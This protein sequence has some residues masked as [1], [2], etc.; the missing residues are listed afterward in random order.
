MA[1]FLFLI[2]APLDDMNARHFSPT[3]KISEV[4]IKDLGSRFSISQQSAC[5]WSVRRPSGE[6]RISHF[7]SRPATTHKETERAEEANRSKPRQTH[8]AAFNTRPLYS[9]Q[10]ILNHVYARTASGGPTGG[11]RSKGGNGPGGRM[12]PHANSS[13]HTGGGNRDRPRSPMRR[14]GMCTD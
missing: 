6:P 9:H 3:S 1:S 4:V 5:K 11:G 7:W 12:V 2:V 8:R 10:A 13:G 14:P